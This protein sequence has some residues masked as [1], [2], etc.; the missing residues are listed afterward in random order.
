MIQIKMSIILFAN[1]ISTMREKLKGWK[2]KA[3]KIK[4]DIY[5]LSLSYRDPRVPWYAKLLSLAII[6]YA[7]SPIDLI[8]D[9]IPV[10]GY[11]DD[12]ILLPLAIGLVVKM[13]PEEVIEENREKAESGLSNLG[14]NWIAGIPII[15]I[16]LVLLYL[17]MR[18]V[19]IVP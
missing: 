14:K 1:K 17:G 9:F 8:P 18:L 11:L 4:S 3:K 12:F 16:W 2:R 19:G 13:I 15:L 10:L 6:G 7:L 5:T